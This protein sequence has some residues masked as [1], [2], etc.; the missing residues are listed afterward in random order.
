MCL[1]VSKP[2]SKCLQRRLAAPFLKQPLAGIWKLFHWLVVGHGL[3]VI[4]ASAV[5]EAQNASVR[6]GKTP[7]LDAEHYPQMM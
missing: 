6:Q 2:I 1:C 4:P 7:I 3:L 5:P